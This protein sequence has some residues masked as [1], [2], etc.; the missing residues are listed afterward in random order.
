MAG[1]ND[2]LAQLWFGYAELTAVAGGG[3][4]QARAYQNAARAVGGHPEDVATLSAEQLEQIPHVGRSPGLHT[5]FGIN[6]VEE[7]AA[8]IKSGGLAELR[9]CGPGLSDRLARGIDMLRTNAGLVRVDTA[10][11][12][13]DE[14]SRCLGGDVTI[15]GGLRRLAETVRTV[16]RLIAA[17]DPEPVIVRFAH[18]P[19]TE[20]TDRRPDSARIITTRG[21]V[22]VGL[23]VVPPANAAERTKLGT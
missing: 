21:R 15:V 8:L 4:F 12:V 16:R 10:T 22:P 1:P 9:G 5:E 19:L 20:L 3:E 18:T 13:A 2:Q 6:S 11:A 23:Q 17:P 14:V 7:L